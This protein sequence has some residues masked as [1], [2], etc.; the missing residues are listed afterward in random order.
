MEKL[1]ID[2]V[3]QYVFYS[4]CILVW[5]STVP[6]GDTTRQQQ[7]QVWWRAFPRLSW[8]LVGP[9]LLREWISSAFVVSDVLVLLCTTT[10]S[11]GVSQL[12]SIGRS[13]VNAGMSLLVTPA[14]WRKASAAER[15]RVLA[16]L[17]SRLCLVMEVIVGFLLTLDGLFALWQFTIANPRPKL[18]TTMTRVMCA[19]LYLHFLWVRR[20]RIQKVALK[21][22]GGALQ[23]PDRILEILLHPKESIGMTTSEA[24]MERRLRSSTND[25]VTTDERQLT[26]K[27][28]LVM[29]FATDDN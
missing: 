1:A 10:T 21:I 23:L 2:P 16:K 4:S 5:L 18:I 9:I 8:L 17:T 11:G 26:W 24:S 28:Y 19:R 27:D 25:K 12:L 15:Q 20:K 3:S 14:V 7:Q 6:A 29:A 13:L 22:R